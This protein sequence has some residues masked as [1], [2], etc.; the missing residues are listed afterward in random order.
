MHM[1][2]FLGVFF[3]LA[4]SSAACWVQIPCL[5]RRVRVVRSAWLC[6]SAFLMTCP[7]CGEVSS[8]GS[9]GDRLGLEDR[10]LSTY[11]C[12][13]LARWSLPRPSLACRGQE[14]QLTKEHPRTLLVMILY[15]KGLFR[16]LCSYFG[17]LDV[18]LRQ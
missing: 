17:V 8:S 15:K 18:V 14:S 2:Q 9:L 11:C 10:D 16:E 5:R 7:A 6:G 3:L 12:L 13:E 1:K 4:S